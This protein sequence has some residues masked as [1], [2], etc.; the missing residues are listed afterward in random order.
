LEWA[1]ERALRED[2]RCEDVTG[3]EKHPADRNF[4]DIVSH[5]DRNSKIF[6]RVIVRKGFN[7]L[8]ALEDTKES[9]I[10]DIGIHCVKIGGKFYH[11]NFYLSRALLAQLKRRFPLTE[12][13]HS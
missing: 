4:K 11:I 12:H 1:H 8:M 2:I 3:R 5:I 7:R 6:F 9:D 13:L 10:L